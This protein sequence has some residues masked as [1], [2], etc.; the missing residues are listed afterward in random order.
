MGDEPVGMDRENGRRLA[1]WPYV[2]Q[3]FQEIFTTAYFERV[4]RPYVGSPTRRLI[5]E[6]ANIATA[7]RF[8]WATLTAIELFVPN[9]EPARCD[10]IGMDRTGDT[11]WVI[12][13]W[14]IPR[15]HLGD[16]TRADRRSLSL[17]FSDRGGPRITG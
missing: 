17:T 6:L 3:S 7:Q 16:P 1:G 14:Y 11:E 2:V 4:M 10:Q 5:G 15:G 12:D 9:F 8:R 13:G